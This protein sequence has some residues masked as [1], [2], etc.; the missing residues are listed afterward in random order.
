MK[1]WMVL[2][3]PSSRKGASVSGRVRE[4]VASLG[5][6]IQLDWLPISELKRVDSSPE[7]IIT[8]GGDGTI[9]AAAQWLLESDHDC[10]IGIVPAGTG[11][12]LARGLGLSLDLDHALK[13]ALGDGPVRRVDAVVYQG[14]S[15][16]RTRRVIVQTG[17]LGYPAH[18]ASRYD[19]LR[20]GR[21]FRAL[22]RPAG[23]YVYRALALLG[24][25][26]QK[27]RE[28]RG[29]NLLEL[30]CSM[31]GETL[32]E[33]VFAVFIGNE[34]SLGGNFHPCPKATL[35]DGQV[36][37]CLVRAGT[38]ESYLKLFQKIVKGEHL[39]LEE[40]I[41]YRQTRGPVELRLSDSSELLADGDLWLK[42]RAI[43][44]EVVPRRFQVLSG[45]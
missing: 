13:C 35:D 22:C 37:L 24:L 36:D 21:L 38:G 34:R 14:G 15:E 45:E 31:P 28:R 1:R 27:R 39:G 40:T 6:D 29:E 19:E 2:F 30:E 10:P 20:K 4:R 11:N 3:N 5:V 26:A 16:D 32:K 18:V 8:I 17:A 43:R 44:L 23:P 7:R 42:D 41:V 33:T 9:N 25:A 12:N